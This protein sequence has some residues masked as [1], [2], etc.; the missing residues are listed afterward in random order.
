LILYQVLDRKE[1]SFPFS[2]MTRFES[3]E[4]ESF[5]MTDPLR[6]KRE[7]AKQFEEH[8]RLLREACHRLRVDFVQMFTDEPVERS[9]ARYL[10]QRLRR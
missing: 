9:L 7:Y 10:A 5:V 1:A 6:L 2:D 3:L 8:N 4:G